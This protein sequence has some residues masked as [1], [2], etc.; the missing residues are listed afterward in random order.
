MQWTQSDI[1]RV[2]N[3]TRIMLMGMDMRRAM[4]VGSPC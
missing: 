2:M 3:Y 1:M 4:P